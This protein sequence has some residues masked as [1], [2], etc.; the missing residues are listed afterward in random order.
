MPAEHL[1]LHPEPTPVTVAELVKH[2]LE[3]QESELRA[4]TLADR[5]R[6]LTRFAED[7]GHVPAADLRP[8]E[9]KRWILTRPEW[10][11]QTTRWSAL[12][13]IKRLLNWSVADRWLTVNPINGLRLPLGEPRR[14]TTEMEFQAMLRA[15]FARMRRWLLF[16]RATGC[17]PQDACTLA[18]PMVHWQLGIAVIPKELH[19]TGRRTRKDKV[20]VLTRLALRLLAWIQRRDNCGLHVFANKWGRPWTR[21]ALA[22]QLATLRERASIA[23]EATFHGLR[24]LVGTNAVRAG[25]SL[26]MISQ[27]LGHRSQAVT[28]RF[29]VNVG[30]SPADIEAIRQAM[31]LGAK[32]N[33]TT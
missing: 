8:S 3:D 11:A 19:K 12:N 31:E 29:Y 23:P 26:K 10:Q 33:L 18:W 20:I 21:A 9:V 24:H 4:E 28:E 6:V 1:R 2:F 25:G 30:M 22:Q 5:R 14:P 16:L 13:G 17:R 32:R 15:A 7:F 27:G